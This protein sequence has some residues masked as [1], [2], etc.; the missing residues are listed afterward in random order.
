M[1]PS[2]DNVGRAGGLGGVATT[3]ALP[4]LRVVSPG[5][6]EFGTNNSLTRASPPVRVFF[7][8]FGTVGTSG[9][10]TTLAMPPLRVVS[11]GLTE[12]GTNNTLLLASPPARIV[13]PSDILGGLFLA[14][15]PA[16]FQTSTNR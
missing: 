3:L 5:V 1:F 7:P 8:S 12:L 10:A 6:T 4:P 16:S 13:F 11:P 14:K 9:A 2:V 15:P